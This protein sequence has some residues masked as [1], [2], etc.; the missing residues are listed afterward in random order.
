MCLRH[1][2]NKLAMR[3]S[4][5]NQW[6]PDCLLLFVPASCTSEL[7]PL[8][9]KFMFP[10]KAILTRH[11]SKWMM[12]EVWKQLREGIPVDKLEFDLS[13]T[14]LKKPFTHWIAEALKEM[15]TKKELI[16]KSWDHL[17]AAW[18][19]G[20]TNIYSTTCRKPTR[21]RTHRCTRTGCTR[22]RMRVKMTMMM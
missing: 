18:T 20:G 6:Y 3:S 21:M 11:S 19:V 4:I 15:S 14:N 7:Q 12:D 9:I 2:S 8:D 5:Q 1:V 22:M 16:L 10:F 13:L 17:E